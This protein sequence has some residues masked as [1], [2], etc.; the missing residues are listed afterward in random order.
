MIRISSRIR[1]VIFDLD[2]TLMDSMGVWNEVD[3]E[4]LG[5]RGIEVPKNLSLEIGGCSMYQTALYFQKRFGIQDYP[6]TMMDEWN[7]LA[8]ELYGTKVRPKKGAREFIASCHSRDIPCAIASSN[9]RELIEHTLKS[10]QMENDF[11]VI[12]SGNEVRIGKPDP[13]IY[14]ECARRLQVEPSDCLAFEDLP[15]GIVAAKKAGMTCIAVRDEA[16]VDVQ[17]EKETLSDGMI[18]DFTELSF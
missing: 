10:R 6:E 3:R 18:T 8:Y 7:R 12:L 11:Q 4:Y 5:S 16:S 15:D 13:F 14:R 9:S 17:D 1:A 2:G